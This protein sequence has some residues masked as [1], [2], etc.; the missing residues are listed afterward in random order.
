MNKV[1]NAKKAKMGE[2]SGL[3]ARAFL[4]Q[5]YPELAVHLERG[6]TRTRKEMIL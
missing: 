4:R 1:K 3:S 2:T 5:F 6:M